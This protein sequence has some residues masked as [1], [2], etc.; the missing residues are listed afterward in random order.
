[1]KKTVLAALASI[2]LAGSAIGAATAHERHHGTAYR[3]GPIV[4]E[5]DRDAYVPR[6]RDSYAWS[7]PYS[8]YGY[9]ASRVEGGAISAPAGH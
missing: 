5:P 7:S 2:V 6:F 8:D 9:W 3:T 1:M 4:S